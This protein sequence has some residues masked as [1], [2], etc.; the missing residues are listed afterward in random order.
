MYHPS[1]ALQMHA[2]T[3]SAR[4][5]SGCASGV[6]TLEEQSQQQIDCFRP[7]RASSRAA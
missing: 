3:T 7:H 1:Q 5:N 6:K 4:H 2:E